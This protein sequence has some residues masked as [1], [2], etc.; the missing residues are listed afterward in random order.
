MFTN[1]W[2]YCFSRALNLPTRAFSV[3]TRAFNLA[4]RAFNLLTHRSELVTRVLLFH[5]YN[6]FGKLKINSKDVFCKNCNKLIVR[7]TSN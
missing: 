7:K 2:F 4:T 5:F 3:P 6:H 1:L